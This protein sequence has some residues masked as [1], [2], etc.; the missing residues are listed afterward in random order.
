M[1][2]SR[3]YPISGIK[4]SSVFWDI[5][6]CS[7]LKVNTVSQE[8]AASTVCFLL[9]GGLLLDILFDTEDGGDIFF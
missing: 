6:P 3:F 1:N 5:T 9:H 2:I 7:L 8:Y 4:K